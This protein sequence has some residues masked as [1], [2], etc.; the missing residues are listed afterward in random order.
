MSQTIDAIR[1]K[2]PQYNA[3]PDDQL[4]KS[5]GEKYPMY[6]QHDPEFAREHQSVAGGFPLMQQ[7]AAVPQQEGRIFGSSTPDI[8]AAALTGPVDPRLGILGM[9]QAG[10]I[11]ASQMEPGWA[12]TGVE[13]INAQN[14]VLGKALQPLLKTITPGLPFAEHLIKN[15]VQTVTRLLLGAQGTQAASQALG[16]RLSG[17]DMTQG[18]KGELD[19]QASLG[20]LQALAAP[21]VPQALRSPLTGLEKIGDLIPKQENPTYVQPVP[22]SPLLRKILD[23]V[24][25]GGR[26]YVKEPLRLG[27]RASSNGSGVARPPQVKPQQSAPPPNPN[28]KQTSVP[29]APVQQAQPPVAKAA[30]VPSLRPALRIGTQV[31]PAQAG[32]G[33]T[34][35]RVLSASPGTQV[36]RGF[37]DAQGNFYKTPLEAAR[38]VQ[39]AQP[40]ETSET[41]QQMQQSSGQLPM[42][43]VQERQ[44]E[45]GKE[46]TVQT[47]PRQQVP[48]GVTEDARRAG[49]GDG[50]RRRVGEQGFWRLFGGADLSPLKLKPDTKVQGD[51]MYNRIRNT[52]GADSGAFGV[53]DKMGLRAFLQTPRTT[54]EVENWMT[55]NGPKVEVRKFGEGAQKPL[56]AE[57]NRLTHEWYDG[58]SPRQKQI[59]DELWRGTLHDTPE[60]FENQLIKEGFTTAS[61]ARGRR[62]KE[63]GAQLASDPLGENESHWQFIAPKSEQ[64]MPGYTEIAVVKPG[65]KEF[66]GREEFYTPERRREIQESVQFPSSHSFPPNTLVFVR[67][68]MESALPAHNKPIKFLDEKTGDQMMLVKDHTGKWVLHQFDLQEG[69]LNPAARDEFNTWQEGFDAAIGTPQTEKTFHVIE[70]QSDWAQQQRNKLE[71]INKQ[72]RG[73]GRG[74]SLGERMVYEK[75]QDVLLPHY[76]RL[77]LKAAID[78]ARKEGATRIA[79]SDAETAMMTGGHDRAATQHPKGWNYQEPEQSPGMRLHYDRTLPKIAEE[80]TGAK[81]ER[82]GFGEH[83]MAVEPIPY[84]RVLPN[85]R[86]ATEEQTRDFMEGRTGGNR[87]RKDLIFRNPDGTPKTSVTARSY[88]ITKTK[89]SDFSLFGK[90]KAQGQVQSVDR[91]PQAR[92]G[93]SGSILNP[94]DLVREALDRLNSLTATGKDIVNHLTD[95]QS[96]RAYWLKRQGYDLPRIQSLSPELANRVAAYANSGT[97][98]LLRANAEVSKVLGDKVGDEQFRRALGGV[99]YEDMRQAAGNVGTPVWNLRNSPFRDASWYQAAKRNP[100]V[101]AALDRWKKLI[102]PVAE[103]MHVKLGGT[104]S[105]VGK[106]T[107]AFA[108]LQAILRDPLTNQVI[109]EGH[110]RGPSGGPMATIKRRSAFSKER[111]FTGEEYNLD[112]VDIARR[113]MTRNAAEYQKRLMYDSLEK[114]GLGKIIERKD[115]A[116]PGMDVLDNPVM[117]RTII[118]QDGTHVQQSRYLAINPKIRTEIEQAMQLNKSW[119]KSLQEHLPLVDTAAQLGTKMQV[120][121]GMDV[122]YHMVNDVIAL[123]NSPPG[124]LANLGPKPLRI[125]KATQDLLRNDNN[126]QDELAHMAEQGVS[127]RGESLG[128][129]SSE[130]LRFGDTVTRLVLNREYEQG[131]KD[132]GWVNTPAERRRYING[133]AGQYNKRFMTQFQQNM[134]EVGLG[135]FNVAGRNFNRLAVGNLTADPGVKASTKTEALRLRL[136]IAAGIATAVL[137]VPSAINYQ[138]TGQFQPDGTQVGE[139]VLPDPKNPTQPWKNANGTY[140]TLNVRKWLML[141]RGG[142][143][144]GVGK[145]MS[146]QV[147]PR[148]QGQQPASLGQTLKDSTQ[149]VIITAVH[150]FSGPTANVLSALATGKTEYGMGFD[151]RPP[152]DKGWVHPMAALS[153]INPLAGPIAAGQGSASGGLLERAV[154]RAGQKIGSVGGVGNSQLPLQVIQG[155][156]RQYM[157]KNK[158]HKDEGESYPPSQY[159][160]LIDALSNKDLE[161]AKRQYNILLSAKS[162]SG[163]L[164]DEQAASDAKKEIQRK[165]LS[166]ENFRFT[167]KEHEDLFKASLTPQQRTMYDNAIAQQKAIADAFFGQIQPK[168]TK[169]RNPFPI[170]APK[171]FKKYSMGDTIERGGQQYTVTG[172]DED[173]EPL[174]ERA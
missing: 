137:V 131:V 34:A 62:Y 69:E 125:I 1:A 38:A 21:G 15:P 158:V 139:V 126:L 167:T 105:E 39:Q 130:A 155:R 129:W 67:G 33:A 140:K 101:L 70:V 163:D 161:E 74:A 32:H 37:M 89:P 73:L 56:H 144:T 45:V 52:L 6:L 122:G 47:A 26:D 143:A 149:D 127:F 23:T 3:V 166:L 99:I 96:W 136:S 151:Q 17:V 103:E 19:A 2:Y 111:K 28:A 110:A 71:E 115:D 107:G 118:A 60:E 109:E 75:G 93:E 142:R 128:G 157:I 29:A 46:G 25:P 154:E 18:E 57:Y 138:L 58:L 22:G 141:D 61:A 97:A 59:A 79:I 51:Q 164:S 92:K 78:H 35:Q 9:T 81:G 64:D 20:G 30:S 148:L 65:A 27:Q 169:P 119:R 112:A 53:L 7:G 104:L 13:Q 124:L 102:Q 24:Q 134:Q 132:H 116:P 80:L 66:K 11:V 90:D 83:R 94:A 36:E 152:G 135:A 173:G 160:P 147:M 146:E 55:E 156:A 100:E 14:A 121:L 170:R 120:G 41:G 40:K 85:W 162:Q 84:S 31:L 82:V 106:E 76:E 54:K 172:F 43:G 113:M 171:G 49:G 87:P 12:R 72:N 5:I 63:L 88:D 50:E 145:V 117:W 168:E 48:G 10:P 91:T 86:H 159:K 44:N 114:T 165:F 108:N 153:T 98:A 68:Y 123:V 42:Q 133:R 150:P 16:Q 174:V 77:A 4:I 8:K 95:S